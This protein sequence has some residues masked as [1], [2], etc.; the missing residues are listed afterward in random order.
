MVTAGL[1]LAGDL[2][3]A[4]AEVERGADWFRHELEE[5][6]LVTP[7]GVEPRPPRPR[8]PVA[9]LFVP[10]LLCGFLTR[11]RHGYDR[12][13]G[14]TGHA[15]AIPTKGTNHTMPDMSSQR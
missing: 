13:T 7:V 4:A 3:L 9:S 12:I 11:A 14:G 2:T 1:K 15:S 8:D 6:F 10:V 5:L